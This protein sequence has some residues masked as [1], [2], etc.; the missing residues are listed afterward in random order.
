MVSVGQA[1]LIFEIKKGIEIWKKKR[2]RNLEFSP[3]IG[4]YY[5]K[6]DFFFFLKSAF[7]WLEIAGI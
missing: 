6:Q 1:E 5:R 2:C 7:F 3:E 4:K